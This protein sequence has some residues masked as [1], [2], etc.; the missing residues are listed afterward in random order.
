MQPSYKILLFQPFVRYWVMILF[1]QTLLDND[2]LIKRIIKK[3]MVL[4]SMVH[5]SMIQ[6]NTVNMSFKWSMTLCRII[7]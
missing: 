5:N 7:V 3:N 4:Y 6:T 2:S 1:F